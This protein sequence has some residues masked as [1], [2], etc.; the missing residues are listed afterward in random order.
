MIYSIVVGTTFCR[1]CKILD[2]IRSL[3]WIVMM[4]FLIQFP[5]TSAKLLAVA[6]YNC[7]H[8]FTHV[9]AFRFPGLFFNFSYR[10][11]RNKDRASS[12]GAKRALSA[13]S[14][15]YGCTSAF[16]LKTSLLAVTVSRMY[17][18]MEANASDCSSYCDKRDL[19]T[20][21]LTS[22]ASDEKAVANSLNSNAGLMGLDKFSGSIR[23]SG[24]IRS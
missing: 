18:M 9:S 21:C 20:I 24:L 8:S 16:W 11:S 22:K 4:K 7:S 2:L 19:Y 12:V 15:S 14:K 10:F 1:L 23:R 13:H 6:S 5:T 17:D 3:E